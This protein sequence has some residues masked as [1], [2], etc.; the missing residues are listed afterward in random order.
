MNI[1]LTFWAAGFTIALI[2]FLYIGRVVW[3]VQR[4]RLMR[5]PETGS[6]TLVGT[7]PDVCEGISGHTVQRCG[8][9]PEHSGC[10]RACLSRHAETEPGFRVRLEALR[11]Y[12]S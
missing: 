10:A 6:I 9:W 2:L 3:Q 7:T 1:G 8:L 4:E 5:C 11:P 12:K